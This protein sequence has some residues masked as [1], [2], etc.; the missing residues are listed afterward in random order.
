MLRID[1]RSLIESCLIED[2]SLEM[3]LSTSSFF[4]SWRE[5]T[6]SSMEFSAVS[7]MALFKSIYSDLTA[8]LEKTQYLRNHVKET[9]LICGAVRS[10]LL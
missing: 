3:T 5:T 8:Y 4:S 6:L 2:S 1:L 9:N 7:L 10:Y